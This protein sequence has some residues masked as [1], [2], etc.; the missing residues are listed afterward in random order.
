MKKIKKSPQALL[1]KAYNNYDFLNSPSARIIRI[2]AELIEPQTRFQKYNLHNTI[3]FFGSARILPKTIALKN[4]KSITARLAKNKKPTQ[5]LIQAGQQAQ[6]DVL[7]SRYYEDA[8][9]LSEKLTRWFC[10]C[11]NTKENF[12]ICSGGGPGIMEAASLGAKQANG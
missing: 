11:Q 1:K 12:V 9:Q 8:V 6:R 5:K 4:L 10:H 3:V 7:M 2:L